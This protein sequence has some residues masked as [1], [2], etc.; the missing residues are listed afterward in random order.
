MLVQGYYLD[1]FG[2]DF[3]GNLVL[4]TYENTEVEIVNL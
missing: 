4:I 1:E 3:I 2:I